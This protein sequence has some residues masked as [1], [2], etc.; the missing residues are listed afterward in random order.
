VLDGVVS[1]STDALIQFSRP[2]LPDRVDAE[3]AIAHEIDEVLG[4]GGAAGSILNAAFDSGLS[5]PP[6][7]GGVIG[8]EDLYRYAQAGIPSL[9]LDPDARAFFSIDGGVDDVA[10]FNQDHNFD[11]ADWLPADPCVPQVQR[12]VFCTGL[13]VDL[14]RD[15]P[16]A[17]ALQAIGYDLRTVPEPPTVVLFLF[18]M[19]A[20]LLARRCG[21]ARDSGW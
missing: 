15:S 17:I 20:V 4:I 13:S 14:L 11:Y 19:G 21:A 7:F 16:E 10:Q 12:A 5:A 6:F 2:V 9:S 1:L 8:A 3:W 18:G